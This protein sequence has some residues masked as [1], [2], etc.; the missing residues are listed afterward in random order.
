[1][2]WLAGLIALCLLS[3]VGCRPRFTYVGAHPSDEVEIRRVKLKWSN[4]YLLSGRN[5]EGLVDAGSPGDAERT[6]KALADLGVKPGDIKV[7]VLTHG[8]ADHS[9]MAAWLQKS[10]ARIVVGRGDESLSQAG[11]NDDLRPTSALATV[12]KPLFMF[13]YEPF[14]PDYIVDD[15]LDLSTVGLHGVRVR[16][17][18]GHTKGS[19]VVL[20][21]RREALV[22]DMMMGGLFGGV[23]LA[24]D[25]GEHY[26]QDDAHRN[27]CNV[28]AL[29]R[30]G[31]ETF[32][33]GHG[34]PVSRSSVLEWR[35]EWEDDLRTCPLR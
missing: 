5:C 6:T 7:V 22:G 18:P 2:R 25:A 1:M 10:G 35:A 11:H 21:S 23:L 33:L 14:T 12:L 29:L 27:R 19:L 34:G 16:R 8:H 9:G 20:T 3:V 24:N 13:P 32:H 4:V 30:A 31:V 15:E 26:Y 28:E 17:M